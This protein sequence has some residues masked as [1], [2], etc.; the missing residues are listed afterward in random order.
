M[1]I[2]KKHLSR[3]TVLKGVGVTVALPL[4]DAM[5]PAAT[6]LAGT[7]AA[8]RPRMAFVYFPHGAVMPNWSP[9]NTGTDF[10]FTPILKPL[11]PYKEY[12]TIV[13]GLRNKTGESPSPHAIIAGTWLSCHAPAVSQAPHGGISCDQ[14]AAAKIGQDTALPS[15]EL[16][17]EGGGGACDPSFGCSY[18]GTVAFRTPTQPLPMEHNPRK[19]FY[20][21]FGQG[22]TAAERH[23]IINESQ[24]ILD[25]VKANAN[26]LQRTL[27][28]SDRAMVSD[29]LDSVREMERRIEKQKEKEHSGIQLPD[30]PTGI[31]EDFSKQLD[32]MFDLIALAWQS[33]S[34]RVATFMMAKEVSMRTYPQI[35]VTDAFHPLSHHQNDPAKLARLTKIQAYHTDAFSRFVKRLKNTADGDGSL[36]DHSIILYG[37]NMSNSDLHNNDPLPSAVVGR[38][39]GKIKGGQHVH[40]PQDTPLANLLLTLLN[41][42]GIEVDKHGNSTGSLAEI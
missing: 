6:A 15:L 30:A 2:T 24:S 18:S 42:A 13:S 16:A 38:G 33:N 20:R 3:R 1:F 14:V 32:T 35:G 23:E 41:R 28:A 4:L 37:S 31:L 27:G 7:A 11:A 22:D 26:D 34:T 10:E 25:L 39:Y 19:V 17:G 36:L 21:L 5:I 8:P 12:V 9:A 40:Y 29:Y